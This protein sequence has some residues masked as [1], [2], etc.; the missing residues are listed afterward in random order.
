MYKFTSTP[1]TEEEKVIKEVFEK[2]AEVQRERFFCN[3]PGASEQRP[4]SYAE[5]KPNEI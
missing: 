1:L 5:D 3:I 2:Y 4:D